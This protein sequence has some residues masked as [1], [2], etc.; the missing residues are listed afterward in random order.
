M[1]KGGGLGKG[2][3]MGK[4][5]GLGDDGGLGD[6]G[7][8]GDDGGL[9]E[10]GISGVDGGFGEDGKSKTGGGGELAFSTGLITT[11]SFCLTIVRGCTSTSSTNDLSLTFRTDCRV[12]SKSS[13]FF[14]LSALSNHTVTVISR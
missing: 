12:R 8:S 7:K 10:G 2:R 5:G 9:G 14:K 6:G 4:G 13:F 11:A 3:G 1:G